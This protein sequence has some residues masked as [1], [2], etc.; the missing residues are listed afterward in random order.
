[1]KAIIYIVIS[2]AIALN[3]IALVFGH[4]ILIPKIGDTS[5]QYMSIS[6]EN[7]LGDIIYSQILGSFKLINDPMVT[8]YIQKLG[9]RL[10]ISD[11]N[12]SINYRFLVANDLSI[13]A[14]ATPG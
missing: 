11:L 2:A 5:S 10:L 1:M 3:S 4:N 8:S 6:Q 13:N 12:N 14:F 7:R 9:N